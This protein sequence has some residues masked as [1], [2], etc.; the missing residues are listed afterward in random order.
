[1]ERA[2]RTPSDSDCVIMQ[3]SH[4]GVSV[5]HIASLRR[6]PAEFFFDTPLTVN[7]ARR[8]W[9]ELT[10]YP[11]TSLRATRRQRE[12]VEDARSVPERATQY[13]NRSRDVRLPR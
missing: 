9:C 10:I 4:G 6:E 8:G 11:G 13:F 5:E 3:R 12:R 7:F 1:V 2:L